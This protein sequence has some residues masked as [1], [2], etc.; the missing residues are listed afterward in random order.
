MPF[1]FYGSLTDPPLLQ[2]ILQLPTLPVLTPSI[3][4]G[5]KIMLWGQYPA[6]VA[7]TETDVVHGMSYI[8]QTA[9]HQKLLKEYETDVYELTAV[10]I[11]TD[12][13]VF[14]GKTFCWRDVGLKEL[15]DG[16]WDLEEWKKNVEEEMASHFRPDEE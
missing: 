11:W 12:G 6:L 15:E 16:E 2:E 7:S 1:F 8:V 5:Y 3:I 4:K 13:N 14:P 9:T 10:D